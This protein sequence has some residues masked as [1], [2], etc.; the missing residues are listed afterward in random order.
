MY[1]TLVEEFVNHGHEVTV[2]APGNGKTG[3]YVENGIP[4]LRVQ[5]LPIKNVPNFLKGIS[6]VLLPYQFERA[7]SQFHNGKSFELIISA[8]PPIT[9]VNMAAKLKRKFDAKFYLILRD[10]FPQN[11]VD[12]GFMQK[13]GVLHRYFRRQEQKL[14]KEADYIG[15][16]SQGNIDYVKMHNPEVSVEKFHE[17]KNFQK[18]YQ[19]FG[20]DS[21][22]LKRKYGITNKFVVVFGGNMGKPQQL[23]NVLILAKSVIQFP[24][25]VFL[26][27]GEGVQINQLE[28]EAKTKGLTNIIIQRTIPKQDYQD[29]LSVCD[30]GMISL[31][32]NFTIPNIPS[33]ALDYFNV[34]IPVLASLDRVTDFGK[35]LDEE[36]CGL[37]SYAEDNDSLKDN[38]IQLYLNKE[39]RFLLGKCGKNYFLKY[40]KPSIAYSTIVK[41]IP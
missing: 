6:N 25:I 11:A 10:I 32:R 38:L 39:L 40:L 19:G 34:G 7:L 3:T 33:K 13:D 8:T 36:Q 26:M 16:M 4:V 22:V 12:L 14:Y 35:I 23:T 41:A 30:V 21:D 18:P 20:S 2:L 29:L 24:D 5:T 28:A 15:C 9:L 17:L 31:H 37:W 1:T 27:L